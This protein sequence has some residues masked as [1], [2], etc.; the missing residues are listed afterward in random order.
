MCIA[1]PGKITKINGKQATVDYNGVVQKALLT[2]FKPSVGDYVLV[3]MGIVIKI[4]AKN[5]VKRIEKAWK[6]RTILPS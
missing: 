5:E 3:Q 4:L 2:D 1:A 6:E